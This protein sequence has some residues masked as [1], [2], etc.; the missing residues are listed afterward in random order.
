MLGAMRREQYWGWALCGKHPFARDF[1]RIGQDVPVVKSFLEWVDKGYNLLTMQRNMNNKPVSWRFWAKGAQEGELVCG[2]IKDSSDSLGR[3][4][5]LL[6]MGSGP[7]RDWEDRWE[8]LP[9]ACEKP[10]SEIEYLSSR[11]VE[12]LENLKTSIRIIKPPR[13]QW[14]EFENMEKRDGKTEEEY[15]FHIPSSED[16]NLDR[17]A[18]LLSEK[19]EIIIDL[20]KKKVHNHFEAVNYLHGLIKM[21]NKNAPQAMFTGGTVDR[22]FLALFMRPLLTSDFVRLW[23]MTAESVM[24]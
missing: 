1:I 9:L 6:I 4:Y 14:S 20:D 5:P 10:W 21:H 7:L 8:L 3:S 18:S 22:S 15:D 2:L 13:P 24:E 12:N 23:T 11:K 19:K 16:G 17:F